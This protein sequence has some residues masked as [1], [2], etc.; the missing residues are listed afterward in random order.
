KRRFSSAA[1]VRSSSVSGLTHEQRCKSCSIE[2]LCSTPG[3][4]SSLDGLMMNELLR[5]LATMN[6]ESPLHHAFVL[7]SRNYRDTSV[8]LDLLT[9]EAGRYSVVV[10]GARSAKSRV[11]GRLQPFTPLLLGALGRS[12]LKTLTSIDFP[13]RSYDLE[14][15][16]LLLG[17]YVNEL[18][19]RLLGRFEPLEALFE[20]YCHLL[21]ELESSDE[22]IEQVRIF[23]L[24]LLEELGYGINFEFDAGSSSRV[25]N[26]SYYRYVVNEGFY[27]CSGQDEA[28]F[29]GEELL[30][31]SNREL[32]AVDRNRLRNLTRQSLG[33][34]L[35][36][37]PLKSRAL[38]RG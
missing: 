7:H 26:E 2:E 33:A 25:E 20:E 32:A 14:G 27:R 37:R 9:R 23:E 8:I 11:R 16:Q 24:R 21:D 6:I 17:L 19:Y 31:I 38:F 18:L 5:V 12:E 35:G 1:K 3:S 13:E 36:D 29:Q 10:R 15:D 28:F 30:C 22:G 4:R 34:L